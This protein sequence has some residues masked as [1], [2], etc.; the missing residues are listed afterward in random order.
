[1]ELRRDSAEKL[2]EKLLC[3]K[4]RLLGSG[5]KPAPD[6]S[7]SIFDGINDEIG[8]DVMEQSD[9]GRIC[10]KNEHF[11][12]PLMFFFC[13]NSTSGMVK[14]RRDCLKTKEFAFAYGY[15]PHGIHNLCMNLINDFDGVKHVLRQ[16]F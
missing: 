8:G 5:R 12:Q 7:L 4:L 15:A 6:F 14:L 3:C 13:S 2:L 16:I 11:I 9:Q 10:T 1:M